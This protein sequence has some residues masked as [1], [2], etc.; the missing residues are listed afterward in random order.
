MKKT[1]SIIGCL[2]MRDKILAFCL[3]ALM[4]VSLCSCGAAKQKDSPDGYIPKKITTKMEGERDQTFKFTGTRHGKT[5]TYIMTK[6]GKDNDVNHIP[7]KIFAPLL[8]DRKKGAANEA[9]LTLLNYQY[10]TPEWSAYYFHNTLFAFSDAVLNGKVNTFLIKRERGAPFFKGTVTLGKNGRPAIVKTCIVISQNRTH[11]ERVGNDRVRYEFTYNPN[12]EIS[13]VKFSER[14]DWGES[15][16]ADINVTYKLGSNEIER[17][18]K[19]ENNTRYNKNEYVY[20]PKYEKGLISEMRVYQDT[21]GRS[22]LNTR[23]K[24]AQVMEYSLPKDGKYTGFT[25]S[26]YQEDINGN[27]ELKNDDGSIRHGK[28]RTFTNYKYNTK[29]LK[30]LIV[31]DSN[32]TDIR[33]YH[34]MPV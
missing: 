28:R 33:I 29:Y 12:K 24:D 2:S 10:T 14:S 9:L 18:S 27:G 23:N 6:E 17:I 7:D 15:S 5:V 8:A 32:S 16:S 20:Q 1:G 4:V 3:A 26:R 13:H 31:M 25:G 22:Q 30:K 34:Y 21:T 19:V 11:P